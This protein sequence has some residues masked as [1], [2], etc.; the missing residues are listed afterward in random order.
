M[1]QGLPVKKQVIVTTS[2]TSIISTSKEDTQEVRD[3]DY[4]ICIYYL[5]LF[6]KDIKKAKILSLIH[7]EKKANIIHPIYT[8]KL[9]L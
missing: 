5:I 9:G 3:L 2:C 6:Q 8:A 1:H 7:F 4:I